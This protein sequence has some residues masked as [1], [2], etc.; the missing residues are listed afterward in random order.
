MQTNSTRFGETLSLPDAWQRQALNHL[1]DGKDVVLHAPTGA[2]KTYVFEQLIES[3]WKGKAVYTVPTRALANDK[4]REW[5]GRGWEVGLVTGDLR[6]RPEAR[7][8]VATLETQRGALRL[9][10]A[11]E[12]FVV[13]EYQMLGDLQ[14]GP[15]YEITLAM[16]DNRVR[17][18]LMSGSVANPL[19]VAEWLISHERKVAL[20]SETRRPVPLEEV[21]AQA[22]LR[23]PFQSRRI[24]GHWPKLISSALH[25]NLGP[26]LVFS[27][28]R[29]AAEELARQLA[30]ELPEV[31]A[32]ELTLEQKKIAG[33]ELGFLLKRRVAYHHSGLSYLKRAG[34]V[35]PLAK[36]GQLQ[37]VVAT[38]GLAAG[39]NFSMRSVLVTDR[40]Y[41]MDD[42]LFLLRPD[43]LLQMFGRAGRRGLDDRGFVVVAP[44]Q[45]RLSDARPLK[46][47]RSTTLDWPALL[48]IMCDAVKQGKDHVNSARR[49][50]QRLFSE[51]EV[52]LGFR[53]S[54]SRFIQ[55]SK[56]SVT[57]D[58]DLEASKNDRDH[59]IEMRNSAGLWERRGGKSQTKLGDALVLDNGEWVRALALPATLSKL[60]IGNPCRFGKRSAPT[61]GREISLAHY[62][63]DSNGEVVVLVKSF[64]KKLKEVT[65]EKSPQLKKKFSR[66][67]WKREG[68]EDLLREFFPVLSNGGVL[69]EF[70]DR[71]R[72]LAARL[73]YEHA[74]VLAWRDARGKMLINPTL[75]K[76]TRVYDSP[77]TEKVGAKQLDLGN[78]TP[79]EAWYELGLIDE[80][81]KPTKRGEVFSFFSRSEGLAIAVALE[82]VTYPLEE[83]IQDLANLRAGHRFRSFAKSESR[84]ALVCREAFGFRD[85]PGYLKAGLPLEYGE[86]AS[87]VIQD[88]MILKEKDDP[89]GEVSLGDWERVIIEWKSL[90]A[91]IANAPGLK[92]ERWT[93]LQ[94]EVVKLI[95]KVEVAQDLPNLPPLPF[96]QKERFRMADAT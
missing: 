88:Q 82:D 65:V 35:E 20:V 60:Q 81:A 52:R 71:G 57:S 42:G 11:P 2:G 54:L 46:L 93:A 61:Y 37:V 58:F 9:E 31:E 6:H 39:I 72:V 50:A 94:K 13:D 56:E 96:R 1:R 92:D 28:R 84:M 64:Q 91:L 70:V 24:R 49:L 86:G 45:A 21:F 95:G 77:F 59:V 74:T 62:K 17:L 66:K 3:G 5:Q 41:R 68:L 69:M 34:L 40:E 89:D 12:L 79:A 19:E 53:N 27:P 80:Q 47:K 8:V 23:R 55:S 26:I 14:R 7:I 33:K 87:E 85:C 90:L 15:G 63:E 76:T 78:L 44:K 51:E 22:L 73:S 25:A 29:K 83:L 67:S 4:F 32:L 10:T 18:L 16:A 75:R 30:Q 36:A 43:E 38:T 48:R